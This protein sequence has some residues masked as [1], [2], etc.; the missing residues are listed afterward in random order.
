MAFKGIIDLMQTL[1]SMAPEKLGTFKLQ[2]TS[3]VARQ[4]TNDKR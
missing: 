3:W 2:D 1:H 4:E